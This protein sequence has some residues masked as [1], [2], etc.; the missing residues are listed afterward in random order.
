MSMQDLFDRAIT[1]VKQQG[2][3]SLCPDNGGGADTDGCYYRYP[4]NP[5]VRCAVGHLIPDNLYRP[6]MEGVGV[7]ALLEEN[8]H[9]AAA[10]GVTFPSDSVDLLADL[11]CA[12]DFGRSVAR[13]LNLA[14]DVA[15]RFG[16]NADA[17]KEN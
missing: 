12:H 1:G 6:D 15:R 3:L 10:I 16:L 9:I 17:C 5:N 8:P 11:Q 14:A 7:G 2:C 4:D 13:F